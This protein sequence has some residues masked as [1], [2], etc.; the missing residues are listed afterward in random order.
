[1]EGT[2]LTAQEQERVA[3]LTAALAGEITNGQAAKQLRLSVRQVQRAKKE[4]KQQGE[5]GIIHKLRGKPSNHRIQSETKQKV[6]K[7]I[8]KQYSD[9]K[10]AFATEKLQENH[11][12][13]ISSQ[14]TRRWMTEVGLWKIRTR[15]QTT[16]RSW[17]PRKEY[18]GELQQFDGSYHLWFEDRFVD[19]QGN[20]IEVCL[21]AA[22]DDA[23]GKITKAVFA[24]NEGVVAV[25]TFWETYIEKHGKPLGI[26]LDKFSTYK[27]NHKHA[28]DNHDLMTQFQRALQTLDIERVIANSPEAKGRVERLFQTLQDR[29]VKEMRLAKITT[30][31]DG[32]EFLQ[33]IF[34]PHFNNKFAVTPRKEGDTHRSLQKH[35]KKQLD[36]IFSVHKKR[37]VNNDFTVQFNN[38]W[39]QLTEVQPTTVRPREEVIME[40]WLDGSVHIILRGK[41]LNYFLLPEKPQKQ[42]VQPVVL[43]NH[44]LNYKPPADHPWRK[45][46]LG[47]G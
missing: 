15:K 23:T 18:F 41:E 13:T 38:T 11:D 2:K 22:I 44:R 16:Y 32:N 14:T 17:R 29:L 8:K 28:E 7:L 42:T 27:I 31:E 30:P 10:P 45:F 43:T 19:E 6:L 4:I 21:L 24:A 33:K 40:I 25:F 12:I 5:L 26:Y 1:M 35:E 3:I 39:H 46:K 9:F 37:R 47:K 34:I 36:H 20:P